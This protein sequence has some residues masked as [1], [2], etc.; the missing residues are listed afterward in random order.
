MTSSRTPDPPADLEER[1]RE[2]YLRYGALPWSEL[3]ERTREHFRCLV[4]DNI[5]GQGGPLAS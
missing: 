1:A 3:P 4:R 5:D 2:L